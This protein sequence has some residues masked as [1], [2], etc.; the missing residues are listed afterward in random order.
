MEAQELRAHV[1]QWA[2]FVFEGGGELE[3]FLVVDDGRFAVVGTAGEPGIEIQSG[4][5]IQLRAA[6]SR[7]SFRG[8]Y[9]GRGTPV[10]LEADLMPFMNRQVRIYFRSDESAEGRLE[11]S[12][13]LNNRLVLTTSAIRQGVGERSDTIAW[14]A[15]ASIEAL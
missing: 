5:V 4:E 9:A 15:I 8:V 11:R 13:L 2:C 6:Q 3:G 7:P 12:L 1:G 10:R 14:Q